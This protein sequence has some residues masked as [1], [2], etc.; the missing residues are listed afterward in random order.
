M[1]LATMGLATALA[2]TS[3]FALAQSGGTSTGGGSAAT[4][5]TAGSSVGGTTTG[6]SAGAANSGAVHIFALSGNTA[7]FEAT[8]R[9]PAPQSGASFGYA[10]AM[11]SNRVVVGEPFRAVF[12]FG[13][14]AADAGAAHVFRRF[15]VPSGYTWAN[16]TTIYNYFGSDELFGAAVETLDGTQFAAGARNRNVDAVPAAGEVIIYRPDPLCADGF[17]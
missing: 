16:V 3:T 13:S 12:F 15:F 17:D 11:S 4:G 1:K 7:P 6:S 9:S 8:L 14:T 2:L 5:T 10:I